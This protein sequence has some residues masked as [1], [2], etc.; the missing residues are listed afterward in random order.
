MIRFF[1]L[2][3]I[4][5]TILLAG[6]EQPVARSGQVV[7]SGKANIGGAYALTNEQGE[8]VTEASF[9]GKPQLIYFGFSYCPD[10]CPLALQKMGAAQALADKSGTGMHYL[11]VSVDPGRDT[12][13]SLAQYVTS[14]GFPA[15]LTGLTGT[16]AQVEQVKSVYKVY[17]QIVPTPESAAPYTVDH[18]DI[19]YLMDETG[20]FL[21]IYTGQ[22]SVSDIAAGMKRAIKNAQ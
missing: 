17:S 21:E 22:S 14:N 13:E 16:E 5:A 15:G 9:L 1:S 10:V 8:A 11:F 20:K 4:A 3:L 18:T 6:C 7:V 12:P 19:I 2:F